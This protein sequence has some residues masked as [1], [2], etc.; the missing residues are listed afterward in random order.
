MP[1]PSAAFTQDAKPLQPVT[2]RQPVALAF[3]SE[4]T[5][6][7]TRY[8]KWL[9]PGPYSAASMYTNRASKTRYVAE[10]YAPLL[11]A[12]RRV[13]D[14]GCDAKQMQREVRNP[15]LYMG[16]DLNP[17]ADRIID[18]DHELLPFAD[19]SFDTVI[20]CDVLEHLANM[21][22]VFDELC[23]VSNDRV[24]V[25]LPNGVQGVIASLLEGRGGHLKHYGL[26]LDPPRDRHRW[27]FGFE[28]AAEFL[29]LRAKRNGF[30]VEQ[31]DAGSISTSYW[32]VGKDAHNVLDHPNIKLGTCWCVLR[33]A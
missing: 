20:C 27:F 31:L 32:N 14:V 9:K 5:T 1:T 12:G 2:E 15:E 21:H 28:E 22:A 3:T 13:L 18:L 33:R 6:E 7:P 19:R 4:Q 8:S 10:K 16:V 17:N 11:A 24:I 23:R 26:P 29:T 30:D 25:S